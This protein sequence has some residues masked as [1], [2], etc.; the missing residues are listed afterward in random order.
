[1]SMEREEGLQRIRA[2]V[3]DCLDLEEE[4]VLPESRLFTD[5]GADSLDY[6]ELIFTLEKSFGVKMGDDEL[7][8]LARLDLS[9]P[10]VIQDGVLTAATLE[11]VA[12]WLPEVRTVD[13][14]G[15]VTPARLWGLLT[16]EALW[17]IIEKKLGAV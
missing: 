10:E 2:A 17:R 15:G 11:R 8:S 1:M 14:P 7:S 9:D 3:A 4:R 16:V 12:T 5:L 6:I 13:D